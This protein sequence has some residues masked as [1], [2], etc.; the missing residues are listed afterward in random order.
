MTNIRLLGI[1]D[2]AINPLVLISC[3]SIVSHHAL[4]LC[5]RTVTTWNRGSRA[6]GT[7]VIGMQA[8]WCLT[9]C[10]DIGSR[11]VWMAI[12]KPDVADRYTSRIK[13]E[14]TLINCDTCC[15]PCQL[16][17]AAHR[18]Q[19]LFPINDVKYGCKEVDRCAR[20]PVTQA[21]NSVDECPS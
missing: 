14:R 10:Y 3:H 16:Q 21:A 20:G 17:S 7:R 19:T 11:I 1:S 13:I 18:R 8:T 12:S 6:H 5:T 9:D 15:N 4:C 2:V